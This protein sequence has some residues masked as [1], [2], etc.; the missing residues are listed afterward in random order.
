MDRNPNILVATGKGPWAS[1]LTSRSI[2]IALSS[3]EE[4]PEVS[5]VTR[6]ES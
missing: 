5:F 6:E 4:I 3:L 2:H 1:R